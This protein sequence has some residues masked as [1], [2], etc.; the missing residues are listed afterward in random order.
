MASFQNIRNFLRASGST[1]M[2]VSFKKKDGTI[3]TISFN[4]R[5][6]NEIK[7]IGTN[8]TNPYIFRVRDLGIAKKYGSGAWRS[9]D[10]RS[11][12]SIKAN[13]IEYKF[14]EV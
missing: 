9:F 14:R 4:P 12:I 5:D 11:I 3:R 10:S 6:R 13:G 8:V 1:I 7:G 2:S